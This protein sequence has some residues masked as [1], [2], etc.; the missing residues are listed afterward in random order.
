MPRQFF[1][2][3]Y[4]AIPKLYTSIDY[5]PSYIPVA[6]ALRRDSFKTA[7]QRNT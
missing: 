4:K 1:K 7:T 3:R 5:R 2:H 6:A